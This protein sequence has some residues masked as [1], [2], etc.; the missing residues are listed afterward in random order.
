[1]Y[2]KVLDF[3]QYSDDC[4]Y[5]YACI[6]ASGY[7]VH[8]IF[9]SYCDDLP[10]VQNSS[11]RGQENEDKARTKKMRSKTRRKESAKSVLPEDSATT[12]FAP[13]GGSDEFLSTST[14]QANKSGRK[15]KANQNHSFSP[16]TQKCW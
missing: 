7:Y 12:A 8:L 5:F 4:L 10:A 16:N 15:S 3:E 13:P 6:N 2:F 1:M 9:V 14:K 11:P